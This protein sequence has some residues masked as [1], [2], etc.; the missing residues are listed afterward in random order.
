M[1]ILAILVLFILLFWQYHDHVKLKDK[2]DDVAGV[3]PSS[4]KDKLRQFE[5][6]LEQLESSSTD[7]GRA[8]TH[9]GGTTE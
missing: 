1:E 2:V 7:E 8:R 6:R 5:Q 9:V 3:V 4:V